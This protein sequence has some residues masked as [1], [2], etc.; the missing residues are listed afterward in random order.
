MRD[1]LKRYVASSVSMHK[2]VNYA[3]IKAFE[4]FYRRR[5]KEVPLGCIWLI[6][7]G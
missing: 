7:R 3:E 4:N 6:F 1:D 2:S 5:P